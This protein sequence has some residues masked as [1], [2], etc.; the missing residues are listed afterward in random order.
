MALNISAKSILCR[1]W[2]SN[3]QGPRRDLA[4]SQ[5]QRSVIVSIGRNS[6]FARPIALSPHSRIYGCSGAINRMTN[7]SDM[8]HFLNAICLLDYCVYMCDLYITNGLIINS[9]SKVSCKML[10]RPDRLCQE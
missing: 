8:K 6:E 7:F 10:G 5:S 9:Y 4:V 1:P 2:R 3:L